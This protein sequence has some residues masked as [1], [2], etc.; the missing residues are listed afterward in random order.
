VVERLDVHG[1]DLAKLREA[2]MREHRVPAERQVRTVELQHE[3][4]VHD[5]PVLARHHVGERVEVGLVR[6]IVLVL[7]IARDLSR[8]RRGHERLRRRDRGGGGARARNVGL[9]R[10]EIL[11][12]DG[13]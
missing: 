5:G 12:G 11:P 9:D 10:G 8:R 2:Q 6:G 13:A 4:G 1:D 3:T 7:E